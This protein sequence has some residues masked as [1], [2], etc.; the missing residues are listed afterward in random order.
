MVRCSPGYKKFIVY[1]MFFCAGIFYTCTTFAQQ[2][3]Q[4]I[5]GADISFLPQLEARGIKF[6]DNGVNKD[7]LQILKEHGFNYIRL[8]IFVN[9]EA[10]SGY[11][12]KKGFCNFAY[13]LQMAKRIKAA[14]MG[15]LL[16]FHYSDTWADPGKQFKPAAWKNLTYPKL[17]K[18]V[19][20]YTE[21]VV[22]S[23]KEQGVMPDMVQIGNEINHGILWP[24]GN[25]KNVDSLAGL[26]KAGIKGV[27]DVD[28]H[29][30]IML[31]IACG[32]QNEESRSFID[33]MLARHVKF[34]I[35]GESYYPRW[36][37]TIQE[38]R[39]N[40]NDLSRRYRQDVLVAEYTEKKQEVNDIAFTLPRGDIEGTFI[41]EPLNTWEQIFDKQGA[42]NALINIYPEIARK[43][44]IPPA[45]SLAK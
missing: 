23:L 12:P 18:Q 33:S 4:K 17:V 22:M 1:V 39:D 45:G 7:V 26:L 32:G 44:A 29:I 13:T 40:L 8:R 3:V 35:I 37:G 10:D 2:R 42:A 11:S 20:D 30:K 34:D 27:R 41:W 31:H 6:S 9:P 21:D 28:K 43:Y 36:H 5:L 15:F 16:D 25:I 14:G 19:H 38:L 24:T